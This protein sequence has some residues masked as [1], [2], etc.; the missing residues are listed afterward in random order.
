MA[1]A[2]AV[3]I[4]GMIAW[5]LLVAEVLLGV[6]ASGGIARLIVSPRH[7]WT[8][9]AVISWILLVAI[10]THIGTILI[11]RYQGWWIPDVTLPS[12]SFTLGHNCALFAVYLFLLVLF[13]CLINKFIPHKAFRLFHRYAPFPV[14][15]LATMH[16][17]LAGTNSTTLPIILP[18]LATI[19]VLGTVFLAKHYSRYV[20]IKKHIKVPAKIVEPETTTLIVPPPPPPDWGA[21]V[22]VR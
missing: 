5:Y 13:S 11:T 3:Q 16:G 21:P 2:D 6:A 22:Q 9:H 19:T 8:L 7:R 1:G 4:T 14:L 12:K 20:R 15:V 18:G 17:L 10:T